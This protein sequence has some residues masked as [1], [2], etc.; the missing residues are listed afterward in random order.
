MEKTNKLIAE[1]MGLEIRESKHKYI[2]TYY[3]VI[4]DMPNDL[5]DLKYHT[6]W[7]W[8]MPVIHKCFDVANDGAM[9]DIMH[10]LQVAEMGDTYDAVVEF[11]KDQNTEVIGSFDE[12]GDLI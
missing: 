9:A 5:Q 8:L 3:V 10:H 11:I 6:S 12:N 2:T 7:D 4:D 1:F